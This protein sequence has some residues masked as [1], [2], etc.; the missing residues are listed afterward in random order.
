MFNKKNKII[1]SLQGKL[2]AAR[3]KY[4]EVKLENSKITN[5]VETKILGDYSNNELISMMVDL[6]GEKILDEEINFDVFVN[7]KS[8]VILREDDKKFFVEI[9][10]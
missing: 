3:R 7:L 4:L 10:K 8:I 5:F 2:S 6:L 9:M 1:K